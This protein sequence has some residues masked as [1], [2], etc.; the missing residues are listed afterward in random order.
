MADDELA[1]A[2]GSAHPL[3]APTSM[4]LGASVS[5]ASYKPQAVRGG[6]G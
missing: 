3:F 6:R 1:K 2:L 4:L 5:T